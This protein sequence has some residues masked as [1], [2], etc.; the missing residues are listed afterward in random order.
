MAKDL[1]VKDVLYA[2]EYMGDAL[3]RTPITDGRARWHMRSGPTVKES[4]ANAVRSS[5]H[6]SAVEDTGRQIIVWKA[7]A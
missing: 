6:I 5:G 3:L 2:L 7:A 4:I 1:T